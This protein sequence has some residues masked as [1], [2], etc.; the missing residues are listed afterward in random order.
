MVAFRVFIVLVVA[1]CVAAERFRIIPEGYSFGY[2][3]RNSETNDI[4]SHNELRI[5]DHVR[6]SYQLVD[7]DGFKRIVLYTADKQGFKAKVFRIPIFQ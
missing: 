2:S 3:V 7:P 4:K 5:G 6:G 1:A